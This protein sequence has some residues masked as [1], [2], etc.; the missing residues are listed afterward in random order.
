LKILRFL[1]I[2]FCVVEDVTVFSVTEIGT[3]ETLVVSV[4]EDSVI[5]FVS[6]AFV[7]AVTNSKADK[8]IKIF[9]GFP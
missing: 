8:T 7:H 3:D 9:I 1:K 2:Y 6:S 5:C 4:A